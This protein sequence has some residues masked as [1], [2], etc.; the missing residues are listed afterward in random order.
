MKKL[1]FILLIAPIFCY[2][3]TVEL[4]KLKDIWIDEMF[5]FGDIVIQD[6]DWT[7]TFVPYWLNQA[8]KEQEKSFSRSLVKAGI[9][10]GDYYYNDNKKRVARGRYWVDLE[11]ENYHTTICTIIDSYNNFKEVGSISF[12]TKVKAFKNFR[13]A[14]KKYVKKRKIEKSRTAS[15]EEIIFKELLKRYSNQ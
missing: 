1:I 11:L 14:Y 10:A 6:V 5:E 8:F 7:A 9:Q 4:D 12:D 2:G 15:V 13:K 3:Q